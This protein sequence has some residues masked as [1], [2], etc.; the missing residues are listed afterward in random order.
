LLIFILKRIMAFILQQHKSVFGVTHAAAY[1]NIDSY[2]VDLINKRCKVNVSI[3]ASAQSR[4]N[5]STPIEVKTYY[6]KGDDF[7]TSL[8]TS[9]FI[10]RDSIEIPEDG[11]SLKEGITNAATSNMY[12]KL[13]DHD[14]FKLSIPVF[15]VIKSD[16]RKEVSLEEAMV[17]NLTINEDYELVSELFPNE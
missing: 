10:I 3:Y 9:N 11:V 16:K 14:D 13:Q 12:M 17:D 4:I 2:I 7:T 5:N 15:E 1:A 6:I 8:E